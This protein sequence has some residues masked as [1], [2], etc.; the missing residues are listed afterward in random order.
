MPLLL[1]SEPAYCQASWPTSWIQIDWD[2]NEDG[3]GDDWRDVEYAYYQYDSSYLYLKLE[4]YDIPGKDWPDGSRYKWFID[5]EGDMYHSGENVYETEYMLFVEDANSDGFGELYL[6]FN[7]DDDATFDEYEPWPPG[8]YTSYE[9]TD[10]DIGD[11]RTVSPYQI[12]MYVSWDS[13]GDPSSFWMTWATD[14]QNPNLDQGPTT[15]HV[16]EEEPIQGERAQYMLTVNIVGS[17]SVNL[18]DTGP[19]SYGDVVEL[20]AVPDLGWTFSGWS[21]DLTGSDNPETIT[22]DANKTVTATFN[23]LTITYTLT[24]TATPGGTT[25]PVP[26]AHVYSSGTD[27]QATAIPSSGYVF[28]H[29]ELNSIN[30][31]SANPYTVTMNA[32]HSLHAVFKEAPMPPTTVG[33]YALPINIDLG[34]SSSLIPQIVLALAFTTAVTVAIILVGC[35]KKTAKREH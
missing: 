10:V 13:I 26:G 35:A 8:N 21:V 27:V 22:M 29:W 28:D 23:Q 25:S 12:E 1:F 9:V 15:D 4:C 31:G 18:T 33:G 20:T 5:L 32:N 2:K 34:I 19:Y 6:L 7:A 14:Q 3:V 17:G 24:I 30:V 16:D 11:W